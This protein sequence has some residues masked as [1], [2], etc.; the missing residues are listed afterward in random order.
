MELMN[1]LD[2][3]TTERVPPA[4]YNPEV[5]GTIPKV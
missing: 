5:F 2:K 4:G 1:S 3:G